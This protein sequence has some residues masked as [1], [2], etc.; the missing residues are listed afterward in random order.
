MI[1]EDQ[2]QRHAAKQIETQFALAR[3][4]GR[5]AIFAADVLATVWSVISVVTKAIPSNLEFQ[6]IARLQAPVPTSLK[7]LR[8][9]GAARKL[10]A[11]HWTARAAN[12]G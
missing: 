5:A 9:I 7:P 11:F 12:A 4:N 2:P 8:K 6:S 1:D 10:Q 3:R